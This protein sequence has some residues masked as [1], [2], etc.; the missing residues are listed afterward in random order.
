MSEQAE[1]QEPAE[2]SETTVIADVGDL[3]EVS[4]R[5]PRR[6][7]W[8][9]HARV[10]WKLTP[11]LFRRPYNAQAEQSLIAGF[12]RRARTRHANPFGWGKRSAW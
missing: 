11:K 12:G 8:R 7:W 1:G 2:P 10:E 3:V 4:T 6:M 5:M 9:G